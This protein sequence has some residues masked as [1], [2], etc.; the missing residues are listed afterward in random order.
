[1]AGGLVA[2]GD[3]ITNGKTR[4]VAGVPG[5]SW[6]EWLADSADMSYAQYARGGATSSEIVDELLPGVAGRYEVGVFNMGTNDVLKGVDLDVLKSNAQKAAA[7]LISCCDRVFVLN[8]AIS[9]HASA[10]IEDVALEYGL[11]VIDSRLTGPLVFQA[12]GVHPTSVGQLVIADRAAEVLG[13]PAPSAVITAGRLGAR[14]YIRYW[15]RWV[16]FRT[17]GVLRRVARRS[18]GRHA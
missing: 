11:T 4:S 13:V 18:L 14:Y 9:P 15:F 12:D 3:S 7:V 8:V 6:A 16:H 1:M 5:K 10:V 17:R 2:V